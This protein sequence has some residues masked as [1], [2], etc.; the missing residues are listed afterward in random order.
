M[1]IVIEI[2]EKSHKGK[3]FLD[4][5]LSLERDGFI[6]LDKEDMALSLLIKEA[7][8]SAKV[9]KEMVLKKFRDK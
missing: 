8:R 3:I 9:S 2:D 6:K 5:F 7:E 4:F 1:K